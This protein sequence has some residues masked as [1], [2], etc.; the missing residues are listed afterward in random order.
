MAKKS[1]HLKREFLFGTTTVKILEGDILSPGVEVQFLVSTDDNYLTMGS[2]VSA[3]LRKKAGPDYVREAQDQSPVSPGTAVATEPYRLTE[4]EDL[5]HLIKVFHAAVIDYDGEDIALE[6]LVY[7]ATTDCLN[8]TE[9]LIRRTGAGDENTSEMSILFPAFATGSGGLSMEECAHQMCG[10]IKAYL[11]QERLLKRIY[12]ILFPTDDSESLKPLGNTIQGFIAAANRILDVPFNPVEH[13][14][15]IRDIWPRTAEVTQLHDVVTGSAQ[16]S[17][18]HAIILGGPRVGKSLLMDQLIDKA[19]EGHAPLGEDRTLVKVSFGRLHRNTPPSFIYQ[20][21]LSTLG[22]SERDEK[23]LG[24]I[25]AT[26]A[27]LVGEADTNLKQDRSLG[28][29]ASRRFLKFLDDH[30]ERYPNLVFLIDNLPILL[31]IEADNPAAPKSARAFWSDFDRLGDRVQFICAARDDE[32]YDRLLE[33]LSQRF[34]EQVLEIRLKCISEDD[35]KKW[36]NSLYQHYLSRDAVR[37]EHRFIADEA[38]LHPFLIDLVCHAAISA[39]KQDMITSR[40][41]HP[42]KPSRDFLARF[43]REAHLAI[44]RPRRDFFGQLMTMPTGKLRSDLRNL[45][46][47]VDREDECWQLAEESQQLEKKNAKDPNVDRRLRELAVMEDCREHLHWESLR[48]LEA[49]GLVVNAE[50]SETAQF[51][52]KP[53]ASYVQEFFRPPSSVGFTD[54]P[55][56]L[57]ISLL[58]SHPGSERSSDSIC[59]HRIAIDAEPYFLRTMLRSRGAR[60]LTAQKP[61]SLELKR[62]FMANFDQLTNYRLRPTKPG[63]PG[64]FLDLEE[65]G[66]YILT[67]L[68]TVAIKEHLQELP[69]GS[70]IM[71]TIDDALKDIPWELMLETAYAGEIPFRVGRAVITS[72]DSNPIR[73]PIRGPGKIKALLIADPTGNLSQAIRDVEWLIDTLERDDRFLKPDVLIGTEDCTRIRLLN[74]LASGEYG[75]VHYSGHTHYACERSAWQIGRWRDHNGLN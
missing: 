48:Q 35:R 38:G 19:Q 73:P 8:R 12:I 1:Y 16:N 62:E 55:K 9:D 31:D 51:M 72:Q 34:R 74:H 20:K 18:R 29:E 33:R 14:L 44:D 23:I 7:L 52:A 54:E 50:E 37:A 26:Y 65:V 68:T 58:W 45:S 61:F 27:E 42:K 36:V 57:N 39:M 15:R 49:W 28:E 60:V 3:H 30:T 71:L 10:A 67:Q 63:E 13:I 2:G 40:I 41:P 25:R 32:Q 64:D 5:P 17:K 70:T 46:R 21:F 47:A 4:G 11:A 43:F 53:F 59:E 56:N 6:K 69:F 22:Q 24:E 66:N 75:L